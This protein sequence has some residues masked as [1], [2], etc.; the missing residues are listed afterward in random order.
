MKKTVKVLGGA[1]L[2]VIFLGAVAFV[3]QEYGDRVAEVQPADKGTEMEKELEPEP[4]TQV[5]VPYYNLG[6]EVRAGDL[7]W[8]VSEA[9]IIENYEDLDNYY[10]SRGRID[11]PD[12]SGK[13]IFA[14]EVRFLRVKFSVTNVSEKDAKNFVPRSIKFVNCYES[15]EYEN[16]YWSNNGNRDGKCISL[17]FPEHEIEFQDWDVQINP[18][19]TIQVECIQKFCEYATTGSNWECVYDLYLTAVSD[20]EQ[21]EYTEKEYICLDIAPK[22]LGSR[23]GTEDSYV[24]QRD[25]PGMK[26][27]QMTNLDMKQYQQ[28]PYPRLSSSEDKKNMP[29]EHIEEEDYEFWSPNSL[30]GTIRQSKVVEWKDMPETFVKQGNLQKMAER[31]KAEYGYSEE[32]LKILILD[33]L[34]TGEHQNKKSGTLQYCF[35]EYTFLFTRDKNE[36]RWIFGTADDWIVIS[37]SRNPDRTGHINTEWMGRDDS[38]MIQA[39]YIL[40]P[41]IW[42]QEEALYFCGGNERPIDTW[43]TAVAEIKLDTDLQP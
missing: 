4:E 11:E 12:K 41:D 18:G 40:P 37:N 23:E 31:Y 35:Y 29:H 34:Y 36:K 1:V 32:Q 19:E 43:E 10:R 16:W 21:M 42:E 15:G 14:E 28:E 8:S 20:M 33:I 39:A 24:E 25:I 38:V 26:C 6:D 2:G 22:H 3:C 30:G 13:T 7:V 17:N 5:W 9:E 27:G